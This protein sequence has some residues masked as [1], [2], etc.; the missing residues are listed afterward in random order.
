MNTIHTTLAL[1]YSQA[2]MHVFGDSMKES[3]IVA[4]D[5]CSQFFS[6]KTDLVFYLNVP[7]ITSDEKQKIIDQ[8]CEKQKLSAPYNKLCMLL[9]SHQRALLLPIILKMIKAQYL[10]LKKINVFT[11]Q[12]SY[13]LDT[14][15]QVDIEKFLQ[16]KI[17]GTIFC[18]YTIDKTLIAGV[19]ISSGTLLWEH[20]IK[21]RLIKFKNALRR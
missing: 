12:S 20:S 19:R 4:L 21:K 3:D 16:K 8:I 1:R 13:Q 2:F 15:E 7:L 17:D 5:N 9:I 18:S 11:V 14:Q 6:E 10:K